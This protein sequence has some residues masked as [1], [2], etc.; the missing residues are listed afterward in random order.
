[1]RT[2]ITGHHIDITE[3]LSTAVNNK[4]NK[5]AH[6]YPDLDA[7]NVVLTVEKNEHIAEATAHFLGKDLTA[8]DSSKDL[9][10]SI[11][12]MGDKLQALLQRRKEII[13]S[14]SHEKPQN[15]EE[16]ISE[17]TLEPDSSYATG[18]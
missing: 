17:E 7:V 5:I 4:I 16:P 12:G 3:G 13:K 6:H 14:Y 10:Q 15:I 18:S 9:Y 2:T 1:M 8:K 11:T